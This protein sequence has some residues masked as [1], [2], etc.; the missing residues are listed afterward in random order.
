MSGMSQQEKR[1]N[2]R[3][4]F[5]LVEVLVGML[6]IAAALAPAVK[7]LATAQVTG[8]RSQRA[9]QALYYAEQVIENARAELLASFNTNVKTLSGTLPEGFICKVTVRNNNALLKTVRVRVGFDED[10][11]NRLD[12]GEILAD[13]NTRMASRE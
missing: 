5:T 7:A 6:L 11:D 1:R 9:T 8:T 3:G 2:N 13:L 4:G 10:R 12:S